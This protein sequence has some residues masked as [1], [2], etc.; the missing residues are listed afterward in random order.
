MILDHYPY[1]KKLRRQLN[2]SH[3]SEDSPMRC[4]LLK[5]PVRDIGH[6]ASFH[7]PRHQMMEFAAAAANLWFGD[8]MI[9][10]AALQLLLSGQFLRSDASS[11]G[12]LSEY[13]KSQVSKVC[14]WFSMEHELIRQ[15]TTGFNAII[16]LVPDVH[17]HIHGPFRSVS[18]ADLVC[19]IAESRN[20]QHYITAVKLWKKIKNFQYDSGRASQIFVIS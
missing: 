12:L 1:G 14:G 8:K 19:Q 5:G 6:Q 15:F 10:S 7:T 3:T 9:E 18:V 16:I 20:H 17:K 11:R 13:V 4:G 2:L